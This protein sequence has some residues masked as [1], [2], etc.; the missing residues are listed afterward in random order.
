MPL[1]NEEATKTHKLFLKAAFTIMNAKRKDY[2]GGA[3]PFKN[4]RAA[5]GFTGSKPWQN[6]ADRLIEK[7]S[8]M[9]VLIQAEG[10]HAVADETLLDTGVDA[11]NF[12][13]IV[14]VLG[15]EEIEKKSGENSLMS[16]ESK[17]ETIIA[18][19]ENRSVNGADK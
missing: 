8:R 9:C 12:C 10:K 15:L 14:T 16:L 2:T 13:I 7:L 11:I 6:A 1:T 3:D 18:R 5:E 19:Y 17:L 4:F